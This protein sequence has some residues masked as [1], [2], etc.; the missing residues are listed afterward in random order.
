M[1]RASASAASSWGTSVES[2][3]HLDHAADLPFAGAA[4]AGDGLFHFAGRVFVNFQSVRGAGGNGDAADLA[5]REGDAGV[6]DVHEAFDGHDVGLVLLDQVGERVADADETARR[7][8]ARRV[9]DIAVADQRHFRAA[10]FDQAV[11]RRPQARVNTEDFHLTSCR[12]T[13]TFASRR[14]GDLLDKL[15][16]DVEVGVHVLNVI[17]FFERLNERQH[18]LGRLLVVDGHGR[19]RQVGALPP[20]SA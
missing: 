9:P 5:E 16:G 14:R 18:R 3:H 2:E 11:A 17:V 7:Q 12:P 20:W 4:E 15:V 13:A 19:D 1:A 10:G 8:E 6:L